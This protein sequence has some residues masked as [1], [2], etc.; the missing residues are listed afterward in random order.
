MK[1]KLWLLILILIC[2]LSPANKI[3]PE[4]VSRTDL[5]VSEEELSDLL[6]GEEI[7]RTTYNEYQFLFDNPVELNSASFAELM[8]LPRFNRELAE[9]IIRLRQEKRF[10]S[11]SEI[12]EI[13]GEDIF[14]AIQP[15]IRATPEPG[16]WHARSRIS[17]TDD[18]EDENKA[19]IYVRL[20]SDYNKT[21]FFGL[22]GEAGEAIRGYDYHDGYPYAHEETNRI[23]LERFYLG[24][25]RPG[26]VER[27]V[28]GDYSLRFGQGVTLNTAKRRRGEGIFYNDSATSRDRGLAASLKIGRYFHPSLFYSYLNRG[29]SVPAFI[30]DK[31]T[32]CKL[33]G[34]YDDQVWGGRLEYRAEEFKRVGYT[35][36]QEK[37]ERK[38]DF[39]ITGFEERNQIA[40]SGFDFQYDYNRAVFSGEY[41][42]MEKA[43]TPFFWKFWPGGRTR[44]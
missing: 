1:Y 7:T 17:M 2:F 33:P 31:K 29:Y 35:F 39:D 38:F 14:L 36:Y 4:D 18:F 23:T 16:L 13:V 12:R 20:R 5:V 30:A 43:I 21:V 22:R 9:K 26:L 42:Q 37:I 40:V 6:A 27:F 32:T 25:E 41:S 11:L 10:S 19:D 34:L 8:T 3:R 28:L 44:Q 24:V 15:L